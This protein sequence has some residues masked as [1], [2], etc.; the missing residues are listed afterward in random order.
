MSVAMERSESGVRHLFLTAVILPVLL[1]AIAGAWFAWQVERI[2][3]AA[4]WID[5]SDRVITLVGEAQKILV[6]E[7]VGVRAF[8]FTEDPIFLAPY[9][10]ESSVAE[11]A[12]LEQLLAG[13]PEQAAAVHVLHERYGVWKQKTAIVIAAPTKNRSAAALR[14]RWTDLDDLRTRSADIITREKTTRLARLRRFEWQTRLTTLGAVSLLA[15]LAGASSFSSRRQLRIIA[16][17]LERE[18]DALSTA[19]EALRAKDTFLANLSHE[20]RTPLT[21]ILGWVSIAR[22]RRLRDDA[23]DRQAAHR[24]GGRGAG[25]LRPRRALGGRALRPGQGDHPRRGARARPT[26]APR[27]PGAA[28][29]GRVEPP[30]QRR[31]VHPPG[32]PGRR[33]LRPPRGQRTHPRERRRH[34]DCA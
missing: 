23:L 2:A 6:D 11:L 33:A 13:E 25:V 4:D 30:Q 5:R 28:P 9:R 22:S 24:T 29:A 1:A 21:P 15:L 31:Q 18:R 14:E 32:R 27:R 19:R 16:A 26:L 34:R 12:D 7:E 20:L 17:L 8:L 10:R 3:L